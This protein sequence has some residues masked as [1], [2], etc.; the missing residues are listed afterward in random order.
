MTASHVLVFEQTDE[1]LCDLFYKMNTAQRLVVSVLYSCYDHHRCH[2]MPIM[3][4]I[5]YYAILVNLNFAWILLK[6]SLYSIN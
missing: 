1:C 3:R 5:Q 6:K 4:R 2:C